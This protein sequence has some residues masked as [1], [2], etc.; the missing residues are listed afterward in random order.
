MKIENLNPCK[1]LFTF[2]F[3]LVSFN[4]Y[5]QEKYIKKV[6]VKAKDFFQVKETSY[7]FPKTTI[8][9][10]DTVSY[11]SDFFDNVVVI[12]TDLDSV[13]I[14]YNRKFKPYA[15]RTYIN[16]VTPNHTKVIDYIF[17]DMRNDFSKAYLEN[18]NN[19]V[20]YEIPEVYEL[21]NILFALTNSSKA[22]NLRTYKESAYYQQVLAYFGKYKDHPLI[23]KL[24]GGLDQKGFYNY[25][26]FRENSFC[27]KMDGNKVVPNH[28]YYVVY[29][30]LKDNLFT[31][32]LPLVNDFVKKSN[33]RKFYAQ[34][35]DYYKTLIKR[36]EE[37][38][39][40]V[41]MRNWLE[42]NFNN[43]KIGSYKIVFSPLIKGS[44]ST[45]SFGQLMAEQRKWFLEAVM[46][47]SGPEIIDVEKVSEAKKK[48]LATGVVF[49]EIDHNYCNPASYPYQKQ[50]DTAMSNRAKWI[51][52]NGDGA[53]YSTPMSIFNEYMT[54]ATFLLYCYDIY[55]DTA[56]F[57][58][59]RANR[60]KLMV[61]NRKY[62]R[63]G[64]FTDK[65]LLLY[66]NRG[67]KKLKDLYPDIIKWCQQ[68]Q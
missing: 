24:E 11:G 67:D 38:M 22:D 61:N 4:S 31:K 53:L 46:F 13:K 15:Q 27:Y 50:I 44:H 14:T 30:E 40:V 2:L 52:A 16:I 23:S 34:N 29:G 56:D 49:T 55:K 20:T 3:F 36:E 7:T 6:T 45:Q 28:L 43:G 1:S 57:S 39:P 63:F 68:Q 18:P 21:A 32:Y 9:S 62:I 41:D 60:E 65:L 17:R 42:K 48:A 10:S 33:F 66:Q 54:H 35:G 25:F 19:G 47:V 59:I 5:A 12:K 8:T 58:F 37:L 26:N 64:E 51:D